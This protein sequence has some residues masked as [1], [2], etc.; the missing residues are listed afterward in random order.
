[1]NHLVIDLEMCNVP[2]HYRNRNYKYTS[3]IIQ[4]GAVL[5]DEEFEVIGTIK[6]YVHPQYGVIDPFITNLTGIRSSQVKNA[7]RLNEALI[8]LADWLG[9]REYDVYAWST[10]DS[11]QLHREIL[12]KKIEDPR[13]ES[14]MNPARWIDYQAVFGKRFDF[15]RSVS[16]EE[17]LMSCDIAISGRLHDGLDDAANTAKLIR[18]LELNADVVLRNIVTEFPAESEPLGFSM[19]DLF[20]GINLDCIA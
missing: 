12:N 8:H 20:A 19:G 3:E 18:R 15:Q 1:M 6:Q 2:K 10:N 11:N 14:F 9:E 13:I 16:L 17:A 5:L 4:V 7:P